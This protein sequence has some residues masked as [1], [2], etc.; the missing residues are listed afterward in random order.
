MVELIARTRVRYGGKHLGTGRDRLGPFEV[1]V[2]GVLVE[3][4]DPFAV[5]EPVA[6]DL[7]REGGAMTRVTAIAEARA[8]AGRGEPLPALYRTVEREA[9]V[10]ESPRDRLIAAYDEARAAGLEV[11]VEIAR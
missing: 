1:S 7:I 5:D 10:E 3:P 11:T 6:K 8:I 2:P 9:R 4:G